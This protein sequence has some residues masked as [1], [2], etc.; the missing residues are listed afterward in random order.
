MVI[1][2]TVDQIGSR[3]LFRGYGIRSYTQPVHAGLL[4]HDTLILLDEAHLA[5]PFVQTVAAI[6]REQ[7]RAK[8]PLHPLRPVSLVRLT[9]TG[10]A[11]SKPFKLD[12]DDLND[13]RLRKRLTTPKP[14]RL[15][16]ESSNTLSDRLRKLLEAT[17]ETYGQIDKPA[18][19]VAVVV[20]RVRTARELASRLQ[21][22]P[23]RD[24]DVKLMTGRCRALDRD[25][26]AKWLTARVGC[27]RKPSSEDR[28]LIVVATQAL[29][30][31]A[32]LDFQG[33]VTECASL[34]ALR[35]RFGRLDRLGSFGRAR[36]IIVG[37][38]E[39]SDDPV[40]GNALV[41]TWEG[42]KEMMRRS[43]KAGIVDF[44]VGA[45][46]QLLST[47]DVDSMAEK[48][49]EALQLAPS[50]VELLCQT[51]PRPMYDPDVSALLHGFQSQEPEI[52]VV[53][54]SCIPGPDHAENGKL[55]TAL[56]SIVPPT[57]LE[58]LSLPGHVLRAWL[59]GSS[60][61]P[62]LTDVEGTSL[63]QGEAPLR[64]NATSR[65][66]WCRRGD[67]WKPTTI[68][69]VRPG[70][71][72]VLPDTYGGCDEFGFAPK[73]TDPVE[74]LSQLA[75]T[76]LNREWVVVLTPQALK[77]RLG[78]ERHAD[79]DNAWVAACNLHLSQRATSEE[80]WTVLSEGLGEDATKALRIPTDPKVEPLVAR[81]G[82]LFALVLRNNE[83]GLDDLSDEDLSS[84]G[85]IPVSLE[86]HNAGV[87]KR[88]REL[89]RAVGLH[90]HVETLGC[91]GDTHDLGKAD[92]R[93]QR[94][95]RNGDYQTM[96]GEL[97]AK[98][99]RRVTSLRGEL[100]ERHEAYSVVI[101]KAHPELLESASDSELALY[102]AGAHHG[103][104]RALM[105]FRVDD[106]VCFTVPANGRVVTFEG[107]PNLGAVDSGWPTLFWRLNA[108]YGPWGLAY[109]EA[110]LR[111]ADGLQSHYEMRQGATS[112]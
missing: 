94:V 76:E 9:A 107:F 105:P 75:R 47:I 54:R 103:R 17:R 87:G 68:A 8:K 51:S 102:L 108:R 74:D 2:S 85:T 99:L 37:G 45:M 88:A 50:H 3:L 78:A 67:S 72:I 12:E 80:L 79:V 84:S 18:P 111:L 73:S 83:P 27:N 89:A 35:Q 104:G 63:D 96:R 106:G 77:Q 97:L 64:K 5:E 11:A 30:V 55:V 16:E 38:G 29:E 40:Y 91:S 57:S 100:G 98:G 71:T 41:R 19:A 42:L 33:L 21:A 26:L 48:A 92:P 46:E 69:N 62:E 13:P 110:L 28:G 39:S 34:P 70:D 43:A 23:I 109:L 59:A 24:C 93:F 66:V 65:N 90:D 22:D 60:I 36:A 52:Q 10:R 95:L 86:K 82:G 15:V 112:G 53:W 56:L 4:G 81:D 44:S 25:R 31:G 6:R 32:D 101:L 61:S 49:R 14:A 1:T 7:G 58:A 20:N